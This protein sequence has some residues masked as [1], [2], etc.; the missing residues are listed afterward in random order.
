[1]KSLLKLTLTQKLIILFFLFSL[2]PMGASCYFNFKMAHEELERQTQR[3]LD[4]LCEDRKAQLQI[5]FNKLRSDLA[6]LSDHRLIKDMMAEYIRAFN[7]PG[8]ASEPFIAVDNLYHSRTDRL[9]GTYGFEDI[10]FVSLD[11]NIVLAA[12]RGG[13]WGANLVHG[14][15]SGSNLGRCFK[16]SLSEMTLVDFEP[17]PLSGKPAAFIGTPVISNSAREGIRAGEKMG[18]LIIRI[19]IEQINRVMH[20]STGLGE[21]GETFLIGKDL[22]LRCDSRHA[23]KSTMPAPFSD[24]TM[25]MEAFE[26]KAM[27]KDQAID[28][29]GAVVS[30]A[31]SPSGIEGLEWVIVAKKDRDEILKPVFSLQKQNLALALLIGLLSVVAALFFVHGIASPL[32]RMRKAANRIASGDLSARIPIESYGHVGRLAE[33]FNE[34]VQHLLDS[35]DQVEQHK[36]SLE[37]KIEE[38]TKE[39]LK[40]TEK[41]EKANHVLSAFNEILGSLN[42][43]RDLDLLVRDV[44]E[45]IANRSNAQIQALYLYDRERKVLSP[46]ATYGIDKAFIIEERKIGDGI[47]GQAAASRKSLLV[48]DI[49]PEYFKIASGCVEGVPAHVLCM[50]ITFGEELVGMLEIGSIH[51]FE[52]SAMEILEAVA[53]QLGVGIFNAQSFALLKELSADLQEKNDLL[54]VQN[55]EL[56]AQ[57]EEIQSQSEELQCQA[58]ELDAQKQALEEKSDML[59]EANRLKSEFVSNISHE[60]RTPMNAILGMTQLLIGGAAGEISSKQSDYLEVIE[61]NGRNLLSL[62]NDILDLSKIESGRLQLSLSRVDVE[63]FLDDL[64]KSSKPLLDE[65]SLT[66]TVD[67]EKGLSFWTDADK[68]RQIVVNLLGNAI[69]FTDSGGIRIAASEEK[70]GDAD[71]VVIR[72]SDTGIGIP[73]DSL[74][75]IFDAF[76]Q[77]DDSPDAKRGGTGLGLHICRKLTEMLHGTIEADSKPRKGS[78]F[79]VALPKN[80]SMPGGQSRDWQ[81][82]IKQVLFSQILEHSAREG[83]E[84]VKN[85]LLIDDDPIIARELGAI[86]DERQYRLRVAFNGIEGIS[87]IEKELPDLLLLDLSMPVMDGRGV[88]EELAKKKEYGQIPVI[89]LTAKD[90]REAEQRS[91]PPNVSAVVIKGQLDRSLLVEKIEQALFESARRQGS[92]RLARDIPA[93]ILIAEDSEDNMAFFTEALKP[94]GYITLQAG[95]GLMAVKLAK[96]EKPDL[97]LMDI[98][99]PEM[100][101]YEAAKRIREIDELQNIPIIALTARAMK[102][103]R[104]RILSGGFDDYLSKPVHPDAL[105]KKVMEWLAI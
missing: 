17:F 52:K 84:E 21:T 39:L 40:K 15:L 49:P 1:M 22:L 50:P 3:Q 77:V 104:E 8:F 51:P 12:E 81:Q 91:F 18:V 7:N 90:V 92:S 30:V 103:D 2:I 31:C 69:K 73:E 20:R 5:Y 19:P 43:H 100:D 37:K 97:I 48:E 27:H 80:T 101:G 64:L 53:S 35:K 76:R 85:I 45:R 13:E 60:L 95:N 29:R 70:R 82:K 44:L 55:E 9:K 33:A 56:Q 23:A 11:G 86:L 25:L 66:V 24:A 34:M 99:M 78:T 93:K 75:R 54:A 10:L 96:I 28:D 83:F 41:L 67:I 65:K 59:A 88:I 61:R 105:V 47:P 79:T 26:G 68:L 98:H 87:E 4:Y 72:V 62:I 38:R 94:S 58:E 42:V 102:G 32:N 14:P 74:H 36:I 63:T 6:M 46:A 57:N 71:F 16:L 89:I